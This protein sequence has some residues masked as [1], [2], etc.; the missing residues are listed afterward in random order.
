MR[1]LL[2]GGTG[3]IGTNLAFRL[4]ADSLNLVYV[5][6]RHAASITHFDS[7]P[8]I[9]KI[10]ADYTDEKTTS[11]DA[12]LSDC[13]TVI[14][15]ASSSIPGRSNRDIP[16]QFPDF[17][18]SANLFEQCAAHGIEKVIFI[19]S[20]G[21]IYGLDSNRSRESTPSFPISTYGLQKLA[22]EKLLYLYSYTKGINYRIIRLSNPYGPYQ[23]PRSGLG[24]VSTFVYDA[25]TNCNLPIIG[26]GNVIR[27]F[28]YID[29]AI[30]GIIKVINYEGE[31]KIFNLGSGTATTIHELAEL[32][33]HTL[34]SSSRIEYQPGRQTDVPVSVLD[35]S[36][37][38]QETGFAPRITLDYG[39]EKTAAFQ[40]KHVL[41]YPLDVDIT[42]NGRVN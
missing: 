1:Y 2:V 11:L 37:L 24:V 9:V 34:H 36:L 40:K 28:I 38:R 13:D 17:I 33:L 16:N 23:H 35:I 7:C 27:D 10:D 32:V 22:I 15:L 29:D 19:S 21:A 14:H 8:N 31:H 3:F 30:D 41:R 20:G 5:V 12:I 18:A 39:I 26:T 25:L 4:A 42:T 6:S